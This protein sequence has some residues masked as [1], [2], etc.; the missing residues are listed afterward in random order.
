[1]NVHAL[2]LQ[3]TS[4]NSC[5]YVLLFQYRYSITF[6]ALL[7]ASLS[8]SQYLMCNCA[9]SK[10]YIKA[11]EPGLQATSTL[12]AVVAMYFYFSI[13]TA[14]LFCIALC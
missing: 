3:A 2:G 4:V 14:S 9:Y 1:M 5:G 6:S 11:S 7:C 12:S 8:K 10:N 13:A